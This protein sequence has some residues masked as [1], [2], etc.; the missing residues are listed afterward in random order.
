MPIGDEKYVSAEPPLTVISLTLVCHQIYAEVAGAG[1]FYKI[2]HFEFRN[3]DSMLNYLVAITPARLNH[4]RSVTVHL[5]GDVSSHH[6]STILATCENLESV[7]IFL[8]EE[9]LG[10]S[11]YIDGLLRFRVLRGLKRFQI[12]LE[13]VNTNYRPMVVLESRERMTSQ[14]NELRRKVVAPRDQPTVSNTEI[15]AAQQQAK[16]NIHGGGRLGGDRKPGIVASRTRGQLQKQKSFNNLG[17]VEDTA[18]PKYSK[19]GELLWYI[20]SVS[21]SRMSVDVDGLPT[22]ELYIKWL[23]DENGE[24]WEDCNNVISPYTIFDILHLYH[25]NPSQCGFHIISTTAIQRLKGESSYRRLQREI[26]SIKKRAEA[27]ERTRADLEAVVQKVAGKIQQ[28]QANKLR[29]QKTSK[30]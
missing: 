16:L 29:G 19:F 13:S 6:A 15:R 1:L 20:S 9:C 2:H 5:S 3:M 11:W 18:P 4:L 21:D 8:D 25:R 14:L 28:E 24:S 17:V 10:Y 22:V 30:K 7:R 23:G 26:S 27:A 12:S